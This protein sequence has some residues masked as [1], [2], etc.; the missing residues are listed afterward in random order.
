MTHDVCVRCG[1]E[2][3]GVKQGLVR[4]LC[5]DC[6]V[7]IKEKARARGIYLDI[8]PGRK[9]PYPHREKKVD[10]LRLWWWEGIWRAEK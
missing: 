2:Y 6:T 7:I 8:V 4:G 1:W 9:P 3:I 5:A 10:G